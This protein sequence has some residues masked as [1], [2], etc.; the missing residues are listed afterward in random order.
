[1]GMTKMAKAAEL[2]PSLYTDK[3]EAWLRPHADEEKAGP[4]RAYMR[5]Q[6]AFLGIRSPEL[7]QLV[8]EFIGEH[9]LPAAGCLQDTCRLL[10][11]MPEREFQYAAL[12]LLDKQLRSL[13]AELRF[14]AGTE[15]S[16]LSSREALKH[17]GRKRD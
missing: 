7:K 8:R 14:V 11:R 10:W 13:S 2:E 15:L 3:L 1:M 4:M 16:P 5:N 6:F 9:G 12:M 17:I